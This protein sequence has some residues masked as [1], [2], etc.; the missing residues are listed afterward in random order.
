M[1]SVGATGNKFFQKTSDAVK[2]Q[3][4]TNNDLCGA[5]IPERDRTFNFQKNKQHTHA[6]IKTHNKV[7]L[8]KHRECMIKSYIWIAYINECLTPMAY[9]RNIRDLFFLWKKKAKLQKD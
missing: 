9:E 3:T 7:T 6:M 5:D 1:F 2:P 8:N 4:T